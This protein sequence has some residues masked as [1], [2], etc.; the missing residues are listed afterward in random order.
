MDWSLPSCSDHEILQ[1]RILEC[2]AIPFSRGSSRPRDQT[3]VSCTAGIFLNCTQLQGYVSYSFHILYHLRHQGRP[4]SLSYFLVMTLFIG[5]VSVNR[6]FLNIYIYIHMVHILAK[7][8]VFSLPLPPQIP[9]PT[10]SL[11]IC[12]KF[13]HDQFILRD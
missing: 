9:P 3:Q 7:Q 8:P 13:Y 2:V 1:A 6:F 4:K 10:V 5:T 12:M 11:S